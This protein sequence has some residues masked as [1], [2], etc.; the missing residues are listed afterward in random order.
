MLLPALANSPTLPQ[1][2]GIA[3][4]KS[5]LAGARRR[6]IT[7]DS[8]GILA[9]YKTP[10]DVYDTYLKVRGGFAKVDAEVD[11]LSLGYLWGF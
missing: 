3:K 1:V 6:D 4:Q 7:L 11:M 10:T 9:V 5:G 8:F 2:E